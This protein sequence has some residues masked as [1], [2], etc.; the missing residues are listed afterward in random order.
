MFGLFRKKS[1]LEALIAADGLEHVVDRFAEIIARK[2]PA[3]EV[4]YQFILAELDGAHMGNASS[5]AYAKSSGISEIEYRGALNRSIP[6]VD[7]PEGPQQLL[8]ALSLQIRNQK[9]MAEFRCRI[10]DKIMRKFKLGKYG[11]VKD[12]VQCLVQTLSDILVD[13][14]DV[15]PALTSRIPAPAGA[16]ARHIHNRNKNIAS[17]KELLDQVKRITGESTEAV[18]ERALNCAEG[19]RSPSQE[20]KSATR[21]PKNYTI[22]PNGFTVEDPE[23]GDGLAAIIKDG[24]F[25]GAVL[26][27]D[28]GAQGPLAPWPLN[29]NPFE[30]DNHFFGTGTS[31]QG[32]WSFSIRPSVPFSQI[33]REAREQYARV[34]AS[35]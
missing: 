21:V 18:I 9:L 20:E 2:I 10:G 15:M 12:R 25:H 17:A 1:Q 34:G 33:L 13:D 16:K 22:Q 35:S 27:S 4:A 11:N 6:E 30:D 14:K 24:I 5:Q 3:T 31:P 7:G 8:L 32:D 19:A 28:I 29:K 26:I 23:S